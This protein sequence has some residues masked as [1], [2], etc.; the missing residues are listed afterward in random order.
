MSDTANP[1]AILM[2]AFEAWFERLRRPSASPEAPVTSSHMP[3]HHVAHAG[4]MVEPEALEEARRI[5]DEFE[6]AEAL[7]RNSCWPVEAV[8]VARAL[9]SLAGTGERK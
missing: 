8:T 6:N 4:N 2:P 9:L 3:S 7:G 5:V 1:F